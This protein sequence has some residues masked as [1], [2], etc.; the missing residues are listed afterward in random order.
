M[1]W[2]HDWAKVCNTVTYIP[3]VKPYLETYSLIEFHFLTFVGLRSLVNSLDLVSGS[4]SG[5]M[6]FLN[7]GE[8]QHFCCSDTECFDV[9]VSTPFSECSYSQHRPGK[10]GFPVFL[11]TAKDNCGQTT[12][13]SSTLILCITRVDALWKSTEN[14]FFSHIPTLYP[15]Y[16]PLWVTTRLNAITVLFVCPSIQILNAWPILIK[17]GYGRYVTGGLTSVILFNFM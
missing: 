14:H 7:R 4:L 13:L 10:M 16:T 3:R 1:I 9:I 12:A 11:S 15:F 6:L 17:L 2:I 8:F 5:Q